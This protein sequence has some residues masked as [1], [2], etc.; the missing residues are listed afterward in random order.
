MGKGG[1][2][3]RGLSFNR[4]VDEVAPLRPTAIVIAYMFVP[5]Q[6]RQ[7]KPG[8]AAA[9]ADAAVGDNVVARLESLLLLINRAQFLGG[10]ERAV[11]GIGRASPGYVLRT[12]DMPAAQRTFLRIVGHVQQFA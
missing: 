10:F 3:D 7:H 8:V 1:W 11:V 9:L 12:G 5:Q 4:H 6:M 2:G